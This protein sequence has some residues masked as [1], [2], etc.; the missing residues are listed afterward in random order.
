MHKQT[1]T[2]ANVDA[3]VYAHVEHMK[4]CLCML[5]LYECV[6]QY[7]SSVNKEKYAICSERQPTTCNQQRAESNNNRLNTCINKTQQTNAKKLATN[8]KSQAQAND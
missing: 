8:T 5:M 6:Y 7:V 2:D 1:C 3:D 4:M